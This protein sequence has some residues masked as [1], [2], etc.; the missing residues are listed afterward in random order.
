MNEIKGTAFDY[1]TFHW[2]RPVKVI[3]TRSNCTVV[4]TLNGVDPEE[5]WKHSKRVHVFIN[6]MAEYKLFRRAYMTYLRKLETD[7][8]F[9]LSHIITVHMQK[10]E[11]Y[12]GIVKELMDITGMYC[13]WRKKNGHPLEP[14]RMLKFDYS[15]TFASPMKEAME[16]QPVPLEDG[17]IP[18]VETRAFWLTVYFTNGDYEAAMVA[19]IDDMYYNHGMDF[20]KAFAKRHSRTLAGVIPLVLHEWEDYFPLYVDKATGDG[21]QTGS[22]NSGTDGLVQF[23]LQEAMSN[24]DL[25]KVISSH[26]VSAEQFARDFIEKGQGKQIAEMYKFLVGM[27]I[28]HMITGTSHP[29]HPERN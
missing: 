16:M 3:S 19:L 8:D 4:L 14:G 25:Q 26:G 23:I 5:L 11:G 7:E 1:Q 21:D 27:N 10:V 9:T 15:R 20:P 6:S 13:E 22:S 12:E 28:R 29:V 18:P 2:N 17:M 24:E